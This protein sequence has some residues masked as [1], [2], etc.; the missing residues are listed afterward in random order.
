MRSTKET[1]LPARLTLFIY[2]YIDIYMKLALLINNS[3]F[4]LHSDGYP[5]PPL[6]GRGSGL[7]RNFRLFKELRMQRLTNPR[8]KVGRAARE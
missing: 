2:I 3:F 6:A 1:K 8:L 5:P 4:P 7:E